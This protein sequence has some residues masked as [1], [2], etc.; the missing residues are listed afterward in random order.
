MS[1]P[2]VAG[3]GSHHGDDQA[4]WLVIEELRKRSFPSKQ[5]ARIFHPADL[6]DLVQGEESLVI[7]DAC[8]GHGSPGKICRMRWS[9]KP[10]LMPTGLS[11]SDMDHG[12][13]RSGNGGW[14]D[15]RGNR[16]RTCDVR[17]AGSHDLSLQSVM[18]LGWQLNCFPVTAEIWAIEGDDWSPG[19]SPSDAIQTAAVRVAD[20]IRKGYR[21]A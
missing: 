7:C 17:H 15:E 18:E 14:L 11:M 19:G 2:F 5:L 21:D 9:R 20:A 4:G 1:G 8:M 10:I 13:N 16:H 6:L 3:L 12:D